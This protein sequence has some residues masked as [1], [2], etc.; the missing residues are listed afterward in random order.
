MR[1]LVAVVVVAAVGAI[2]GSALA[3]LNGTWSGRFIIPQEVGNIPSSAYPIAKLVVTSASVSA[4]FHGKT[5]A[6]HDPE[7]AVSTCVVRLR[8]NAALSSN[9]WRLY[10]GVGK[11]VL[12]GSISGGFPEFSRC[13]VSAGNSRLVLRLRPAGA[14]LKA[15]FG[16]RDGKGEPEFGP[17]GFLGYLHH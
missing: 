12:T 14:K 4:E 7:T 2:A 17:G 13:Q 6:A 3:G 15:E 16:Q 11:A 9:G 10:E 5:G 8:Y 1:G